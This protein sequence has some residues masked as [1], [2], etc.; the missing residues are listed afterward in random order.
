MINLNEQYN[1]GFLP[2]IIFMLT[3][4]RI[5]TWLDGINLI[6]YTV[7]LLPF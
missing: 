3:Q 4:A 7:L 5:V 2:D 6:S 1:D